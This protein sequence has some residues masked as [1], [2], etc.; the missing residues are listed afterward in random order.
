MGQSQCARYATASI[1]IHRHQLLHVSPALSPP[2]IHTPKIQVQCVQRPPLHTPCASRSFYMQ[3]AAV[4]QQS[5][6]SPPLLL[7]SPVDVQK[8][9]DSRAC[10][11]ALPG[12][13][14]MHAADATIVI[15]RRRETLNTSKMPSTESLL[16]AVAGSHGAAS[17][18]RGSLQREVFQTELLIELFYGNQSFLLHEE[19]FL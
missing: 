7:A 13:V 16:D 6:H 5:R 10:S 18:R 14:I 19:F 8:L 17:R 2:A 9:I 15:C 4:V 3:N 12:A 1:K 11:R